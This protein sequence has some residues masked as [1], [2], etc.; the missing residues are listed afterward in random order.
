MAKVL[1]ATNFILIMLCE[2][3]FTDI[4]GRG[5]ENAFSYDTQEKWVM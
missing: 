1:I 5:L 2:L 3:R 4:T